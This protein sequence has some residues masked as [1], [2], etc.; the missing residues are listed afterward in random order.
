M[1]EKSVYV[2]DL[3]EKQKIIS[4]FLVKSK[5]APLNKK[6][7]PYL[8]ILLSDKTGDIEARV[9]ENVQEISERFES[10]DIVLVDGI[11]QNYQGRLQLRISDVN[12]VS[13]EDINIEDY[14]PTSPIPINRLWDETK[15]LLNSITNFDLKRLISKVFEDKNLVEM[16][17]K[18]PAAKE[19][20][21]NFVG[22]L[23]YHTLSMMKIANFIASHYPELNRDM[24]IVGVFFH[25]IGKIRELSVD[26]FFDYTDE[27]KLLGHIVIGDRILTDLIQRVEGFPVELAFELRH[28][29][30]SHH[31]DLSKGSPK[32]PM[33]M[34]ALI[35]SFIDD[36]DARMES[37]RKIFEKEDGKRWTAYQKMYERSL[38]RSSNKDAVDDLTNS[39]DQ[40]FKPFAQMNL[41]EL[42]NKGEK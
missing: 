26:N 21:H 25:D 14:L 42:L 12:R 19:I 13:R 17:K 27:G 20:H 4:P 39:T 6:G 3:K 40:G 8:N 36:M 34:E 35:V 31:G 30:L 24:L 23:L 28:I 7:D 22:G 10:G 38:F 41:I 1:I 37:W 15:Q 16:I 33:T 5:A 18:A 32:L 2:K 9:W 11:A 29:L